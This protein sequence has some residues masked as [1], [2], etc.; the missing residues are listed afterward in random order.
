LGRR[1][2]VVPAGWHAQREPDLRLNE[3]VVDDDAAGDVVP[4]EKPVQL[5]E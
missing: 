3:E 1:V 5:R 2:L 4:D